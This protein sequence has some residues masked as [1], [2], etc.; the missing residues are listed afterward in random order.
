M[1]RLLKLLSLSL[2]LLTFN[3]QAVIELYEFNTPQQEVLYHQMIQELRCVVCQNQS[4]AESNAP[5]AQDLRRQL[6]KL[7]TENNAD[8]QQI[9]DYMTERYGDFVLYKPP[10]QANT[11]LLWLGPIL[12]L[13]FAL[14]LGVQFIKRSQQEAK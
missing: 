14:F 5:I 13:F 12:L 1:N 8:K 4:L 2:M 3:A 10:L 11:L 7:I 9:V 6:H